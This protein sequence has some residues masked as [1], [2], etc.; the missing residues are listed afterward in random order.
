MK[1]TVSGVGAAI[2][3]VAG[4]LAPAG[5]AH[6]EQP[7]IP[8]CVGTTTSTNARLLPPGGLGARRSGFAQVDDGQP[9]FGDNIHILK[10]GGVP[11]S[12]APNTCND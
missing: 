11:D 1:H 2:V 4:I 9:G 3:A 8:N 5:L 7:A 10:A 12:F 6:A